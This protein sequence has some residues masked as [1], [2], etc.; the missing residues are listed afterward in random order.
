MEEDAGEQT[1]RDH[2]TATRTRFFQGP[3]E[4]AAGLQVR[5]RLASTGTAASEGPQACPP[6]PPPPAIGDGMWAERGLEGR[7]P[8]GPPVEN[9]S[10]AGVGC[11]VAA[12]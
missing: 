4:L 1:L 5:T 11:G 8:G 6:R 2:P 12:Q 3:G 9:A 7:H 10:S